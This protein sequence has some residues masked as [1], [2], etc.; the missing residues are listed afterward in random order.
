MR[1]YFLA[2]AALGVGGIATLF[3]M[4]EFTP[5]VHTSDLAREAMNVCV[6]DKNTDLK[7]GV[8]CLEGTLAA[9]GFKLVHVDK[10]KSPGQ[11]GATATQY[12]LTFRG[13]GKILPLGLYSP[14]SGKIAV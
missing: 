9:D 10:K 11:F 1:N 8:E 6:P 4:A 5:E 3:A 14:D 12:T 2:G 13:H 7:T